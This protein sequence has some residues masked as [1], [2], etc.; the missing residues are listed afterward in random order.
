LPG[1]PTTKRSKRTD[2]WY[3]KDLNELVYGV[4]RN[5][6]LRNL[7]D[8]TKSRC[9]NEQ[10]AEDVTAVHAVQNILA[11]GNAKGAVKV[12]KWLE[13]EQKWKVLVEGVAATEPITQLRIASDLTMVAAVGGG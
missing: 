11:Y 9:F 12:V 5:I 13:E 8:P 4:R 7:G 1:N 10:V 6:I 2:W 3:N